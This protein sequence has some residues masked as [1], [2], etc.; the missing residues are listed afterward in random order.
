MYKSEASPYPEERQLNNFI[1]IITKDGKKFYKCGQCQKLFAD[2]ESAKV[3]I[4]GGQGA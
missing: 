4:C 2:L 1:I 3:H